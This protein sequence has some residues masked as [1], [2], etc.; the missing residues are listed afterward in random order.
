MSFPAARTR[1]AEPEVTAAAA[2]PFG[3]LPQH[4]QDEDGLAPFEPLPLDTWVR[5]AAVHPD[6]SSDVEEKFAG[7]PQLSA[8]VIDDTVRRIEK[9]ARACIAPCATVHPFGS[10]VNGFGETTSDL[11]VFVAVDEEE[12]AYY[13]GFAS[14]CRQERQL[15]EVQQ[16][17]GEA[18]VGPASPGRHQPERAADTGK[19]AI[20]CAVQQLADFLPGHSFKVVRCLP[21]AR[22]PLVT[23][24]DKG[25]ELDEIDVSINNRLPLYNSRLLKAY[26]SLDDRVRP[27]VLLVKDWAKRMRV[28]GANEGNLSSYTWTIMVVY[29]LQLAGVLPSLQALA[30]SPNT[31]QDVDYWGHP[32]EFNTGFVRAEDYKQERERAAARQEAGGSGGEHFTLGHLLFGFFHFFCHEY[33]WGDESRQSEVVSIRCADRRRAD[34]WFLLCGKVHPEPNLHVEDPIEQRDL[35]IVLRRERLAQLRA[36]LDRAAALL[37]G[38]GSLEELLS[39]RPLGPLA[40]AFARSGRHRPRRARSGGRKREGKAGAATEFHYSIQGSCGE[41]LTLLPR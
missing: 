36:E 6:L 2:A 13:M 18:G 17:L 38:G 7:V 8:S 28:C 10:T 39:A 23:L 27:L 29:F 15:A 5:G 11:D 3:F 34:P 41:V 14:Q 9:G 16:Q 21:H 12:L 24:A 35:N 30:D 31:V 32:C 1:S 20:S 22:R 19:G 26:S 25:G 37:A 40:L 4:G 33:R